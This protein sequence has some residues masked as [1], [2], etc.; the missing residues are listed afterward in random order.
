MQ[1]G[2]AD[3]EKKTQARVRM[4]GIR[5][6]KSTALLSPAETHGFAGSGVSGHELGQ[7]SSKWRCLC[8]VYSA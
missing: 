3:L 6:S 4:F 1:P 8:G 7:G 5:F 2:L